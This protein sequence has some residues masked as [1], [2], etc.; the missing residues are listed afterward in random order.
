MAT[1][2]PAFVRTIFN[3]FPLITLPPLPISNHPLP[4][5]KNLTFAPTS[6]DDSLMTLYYL[7]NH[8]PSVAIH[9]LLVMSRVPHNLRISTSEAYPVHPFIVPRDSD[10]IVTSSALLSLVER[11][12]K[13]VVQLGN[14]KVEEEAWITLMSTNLGNARLLALHLDMM[15]WHAPLMDVVFGLEERRVAELMKRGWDRVHSDFSVAVDALAAKVRVT[16]K[17]GDSG[18]ETEWCRAVLFAHLQIIHAVHAGPRLA[19]LKRQIEQKKELI[20]FREDV[21][22]SN[23]LRLS[24]MIG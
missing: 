5:H 14:V 10:E 16:Q 12:A 3:T 17:T 9:T 6:C 19:I 7:P 24:E 18:F 22:T 11:H 15:P 1:T 23:T 2:I 21:L 20:G 8:A 13:Q 4:Q